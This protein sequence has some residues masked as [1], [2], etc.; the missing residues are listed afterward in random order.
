MDQKNVRSTDKA[1][2]LA[3]AVKKTLQQRTAGLAPVAAALQARTNALKAADSPKL[4]QYSALSA[5]LALAQ[6]ATRNK[7]QVSPD[8][9]VVQAAIVN[10]LNQPRTDCSLV[11]TDPG[12]VLGSKTRPQLAN[13]D[14]YATILLRKGE[15]PTIVDGT[16]P[17]YVRVID[18]AGREV[19]WPTTPLTAK[20]GTAAVFR[21]VVPG[22]PLTVKPRPDTR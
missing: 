20:S 16:A 12:D 2:A 10:E 14:G 15:F 1:T 7:P 21:V 18:G 8:T 17:V 5:S 6:A 13:A 3:T 22:Q 11:L 9:Y 19:F 4:A